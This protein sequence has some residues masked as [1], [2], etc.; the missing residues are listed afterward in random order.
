MPRKYADLAPQLVDLEDGTN[1]WSFE[2][3]AHLHLFGLENV[4]GKDPAELS[5]RV[6]FDDLPTAY[7]EPKARLQAMEVDGIDTGLFFPS[8]AGHC[9]VIHDDDLY[10]ECLRA[11]NDMA[12]DWCQDGDPNRMLPTAL[13]PV[14][15]LEPAMNE[16]ARVAKKGFR[17]F[18]FFLS[19]TGGPF[20]TPADDPFWALAA[21]MG[22]VVSMHGGGRGRVK[23]S[24]E[25]VAA[26]R[27]QPVVPRP[28][29]SQ[30]PIAA[31]RAAG[32]G[33]PQ[34]LALMLGTGVLERH[35]NLKVA[36]IETSA[37]WLPSM[38]ERMDAEHT[39]H[40]WLSDD[41]LPLMPSE[42]F[43]RQVKISID[44]EIAGVKHRHQIG[45]D[46]LM[47]GTDFPHIGAYYP[48]TR[49]Y[50]DL[51]F[52]GVPEDEVTAILWDNAAEF[53]GVN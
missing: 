16:L 22:I 47:F 11:Y 38:L 42:Y 17:H 24:A 9:S 1:A 8:V 27:K 5:W 3:G 21:E 30:I 33:A 10:L 35:P 45:V 14:L 31:G 52:D 46:N 51:A 37:G 53:F 44:R 41:S 13:I 36:L 4:G 23:M 18:Q 48:H 29:D 26:A 12:W 43:Q 25:A 34:S 19:P 49:H 20:P 32:L 28:P 15:G 6:R 7:H 39:Q 50:V 2:G 40:R